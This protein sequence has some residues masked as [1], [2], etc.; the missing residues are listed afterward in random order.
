LR[1][2][3]DHRREHLA[4]SPARSHDDA[5]IRVWYIDAFIE[6]TRG[7]Y[8]V[9]SADAEIVEDLAALTPSRRPGDEIDRHQRI[10]PVD[11][12]VG[13]AHGL[14][15][16]QGAVGIPDGLRESAEQFVLATTPTP[17]RRLEDA[18]RYSRQRPSA[19]IVGE[20]P[21]G[22]NRRTA[23]ASLSPRRRRW[24]ESLFRFRCTRPVR[25]RTTTPTNATRGGAH[26]PS[27]MACSITVADAEIQ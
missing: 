4:S 17:T 1:P 7:R 14:G 10:E 9:E 6:H 13:G 2:P 19:S 16:D 21:P 5:K 24:H 3:P 22:E 8:G 23:L 18:S 11:G 20:M 27:L 26:T 12:M 15:E 25:R